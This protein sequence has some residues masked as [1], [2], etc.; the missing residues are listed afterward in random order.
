MFLSGGPAEPEVDY[1]VL[2]KQKEILLSWPRPF[3]W[4]D[5]G[6]TKYHIGCMD[7]STKFHDTFLDNIDN[8]ATVNHTV[9]LPQNT[10][11]CNTLQCNVTAFNLLN[12][13]TPSVTDISIPLREC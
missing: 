12:G 10:Q 2:R 11:E 9:K 3:T 4:E 6:I 8:R 13:S 1:E 7:S 5:Y